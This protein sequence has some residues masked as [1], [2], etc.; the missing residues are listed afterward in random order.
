MPAVAHVDCCTP[1]QLWCLGLSFSGCPT[2]IN[3]VETLACTPAILRRG[4]EWFS[5]F[6]RTN[7][8][9]TKLYCISGH[10]NRPCTVEET[11][12]IPLKELIERHAGEL[13][14]GQSTTIQQAKYRVLQAQH[15][16][17]TP[18]T[19]RMMRQP[20]RV[21]AAAAAWSQPTCLI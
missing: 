9:G 3:N 13:W 16:A 12:S 11:M 21:V 5:S 14:A 19:P 6:G 10:V 8:S 4:P 15:T 18:W 17:A 7:N 20:L 1:H 2:T